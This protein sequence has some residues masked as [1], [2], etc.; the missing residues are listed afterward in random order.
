MKIYWNGTSKNIIGPKIRQLRTSQRLSQAA[1]AGR[2]QL[3][4]IGDKGNRMRLFLTESGSKKALEN[5]DKAFIQ[6]LNHAKVVRGHLQ[7]DRP[8]GY[9]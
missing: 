7:Y 3:L 9:L 4:G 2:L 6:I 5:Q 8:N 1:L